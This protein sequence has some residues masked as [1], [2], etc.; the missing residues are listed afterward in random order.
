MLNSELN[1]VFFIQ[2]FFLSYGQGCGRNGY[3]GIYTKISSYTE[4]LNK[5]ISSLDLST[6]E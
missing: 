2:I 5:I 1:D 6:N 4:W 3:P